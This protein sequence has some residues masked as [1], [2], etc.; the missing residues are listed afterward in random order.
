MKPHHDFIAERPVA[1]HALPGTQRQARVF[2]PE[3]ALARLAQ[4]LAADLPE[5]LVALAGETAPEVTVIEPRQGVMRELLSRGSGP[6]SHGLLAS[7]D[8][9]A[10]L[11]V[12]IDCAGALQLVDLA[13]GGAGH[14]PEPVPE[15]L[16]LSAQLVLARLEAVVA[17]CVARIAGI[18]SD[19]ETPALA[20]LRRDTD[21]AALRPFTA[22]RPLWQVGF[23]IAFGEAEP[24]TIRLTMAADHAPLLCGSDDEDA[25]P[26]TRAGQPP[27]H[28]ASRPDFGAIPLTL[29]ATL[30]DMRVPLARIAALRPGDVLP[31]S[32][33]RQV[34]LS[35][36]GTTIAHGAAGE[37]DDRV[38]LQIIHAFSQEET[39]S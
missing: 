17:E 7:P 30:V 21:I 31:V 25:P 29:R 23:E 18:E 13:F 37:I 24:W 12:S 10:R 19:G 1:R 2:D 22:D 8:G 14:V 26:A 35:I 32:V 34:P 36:G 4:R 16:P 27:E 39:R 20:P 33:A 15:R 38:A 28:G 9:S 11:L 5:T 6:C 3:T